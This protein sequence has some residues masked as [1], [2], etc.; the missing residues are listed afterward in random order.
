MRGRTADGIA[1]GAADEQ[2]EIS[3]RPLEWVVGWRTEFS[4]T[5][6]PTMLAHHHAWV[7]VLVEMRTGADTALLRFDRDPIALSDPAHPRRFWVQR[8]LRI[9]GAPAQA[10]QG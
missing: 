4:A 7:E 2:V 10:G 1:R 6:P 9:R 5:L 8:H 3:T